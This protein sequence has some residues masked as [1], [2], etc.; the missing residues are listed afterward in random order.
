MT[1]PA[2]VRRN[3]QSLSPSPEGVWSVVSRFATFTVTRGLALRE[4]VGP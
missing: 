1:A 3:E 2:D 4:S